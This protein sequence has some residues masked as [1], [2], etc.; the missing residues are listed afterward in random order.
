MMSK[1]WAL[2]SHLRLSTIFFIRAC[3]P[4]LLI[5]YTDSPATT[6]SSRCNEEN[7]AAPLNT[8]VSVFAYVSWKIVV[9]FT[10]TMWLVNLSSHEYQT[11]ERQHKELQVD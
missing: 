3:T 10:Q 1:L 9:S 4:C 11:L 5:G 2:S 6:C 7:R 8:F